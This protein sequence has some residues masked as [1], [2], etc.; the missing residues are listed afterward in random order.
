M[1]QRA[2]LA[3]PFTIAW[4]YWCAF[5]AALGAAG[6]TQGALPDWLRLDLSLLEFAQAHPSVTEEIAG[7][8]QDLVLKSSKA[9]FALPPAGT[10]FVRR[11]D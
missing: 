4:V 10:R 5:L 6:S 11:R 7:P 1:A 2:N 9:C 3:V 8:L